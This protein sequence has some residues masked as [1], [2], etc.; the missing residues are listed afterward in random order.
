MAPKKKS[1][2]SKQQSLEAGRRKLEEFRARKQRGEAAKQKKADKAKEEASNAGR[3]TDAPEE[4]APLPSANPLPRPEPRSD[5]LPTRT[6][7]TQLPRVHHEEVSETVGRGAASSVTAVPVGGESDAQREAFGSEASPPEP[8][9][10]VVV[11]DAKTQGPEESKRSTIVSS[12]HEEQSELISDDPSNKQEQPEPEEVEA[13]QAAT[14]AMERVAVESELPMSTETS[15][16]SDVSPALSSTALG[17][18]PPSAEADNILFSSPAGVMMNPTLSVVE[19]A[20][21]QSP[22]ISTSEN[23]QRNGR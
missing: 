7:P 11:L 20:M 9:G 8:V 5:T 4:R 2:V 22:P 18:D 23:H 12:H 16:T 19:L 13:L 10:D 6:E 21:E 17:D 1:S 15:L 3:A 14:E